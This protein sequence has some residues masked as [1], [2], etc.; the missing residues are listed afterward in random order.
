MHFLGAYKASYDAFSSEVQKT[1]RI[2]SL[3]RVAPPGSQLRK[4]THIPLL[5]ATPLET[6]EKAR[7]VNTGSQKHVSKI[8]HRVSVFLE[9]GLLLPYTHTP[10]K[11]QYF[12]IRRVPTASHRALNHH[13]EF[14]YCNTAFCNS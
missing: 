10:F 3:S 14:Y 6:L 12:L 7:L 2:R 1:C 5:I 9:Y 13:N 11:K 4:E 8:Y